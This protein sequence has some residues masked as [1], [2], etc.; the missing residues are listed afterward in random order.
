VQTWIIFLVKGKDSAAVHRNVS[1]QVFTCASETVSTYNAAR[2]NT[3]DPLM[4][5]MHLSCRF[6]VYA[7]AAD[8]VV[9]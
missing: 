7:V 8:S 6:T 5:I 4:F 9:K 1:F 3:A 2:Y